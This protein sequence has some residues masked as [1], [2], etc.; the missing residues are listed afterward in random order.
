[1]IPALVAVKVLGDMVESGKTGINADEGFYMQN[2]LGFSATQSGMAM[3]GGAEHFGHQRPAEHPD[4]TRLG[5]DQ[6]D[7]PGGGRHSHRSAALKGD[8]FV[9]GDE[10]EREFTRNLTDKEKEQAKTLLH[11]LLD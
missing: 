9:L 4:R 2:M 1:M 5:Y 3:M 10:L 11:K 6:H 7:A 8:L